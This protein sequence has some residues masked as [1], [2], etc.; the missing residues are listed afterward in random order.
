M[1]NSS[2]VLILRGGSVAWNQWRADNPE[3]KP[4]LSYLNFESTEA[5]GSPPLYDIVDISNFNFSNTDLRGASIRNAYAV[6]ASFIG[7]Y[8]VA[9]DLC[10]ANF[11]YCD[12]S[13]A[14]L[15]LSKIG[16]TEFEHCTFR[17]TDFAYCTAQ[18]TK[19]V[20]SEFFEVDMQYMQLA[21]TDFSNAKLH[22]AFVYGIAAWDL[23]LEGCSQSDLVITNPD[24]APVTVSD[25]EVAQFIYLMLNN[26]R[27]RSILNVVTS[28]VVLILGRF[29]EAR[30]EVLK[31]LQNEL[32]QRDYVPVI[33]DFERPHSR[34][35]LETA[36]TLAHMACFIVADFTAQ[37]DVRREVQHIA[38]T[39]LSVPIVPLLQESEK[40]L[41]ITLQDL[42]RHPGILP[43]IRYSNSKQLCSQI[44]EDIINPALA[45]GIELK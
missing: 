15:R 36:S 38:N 17:S 29:T 37:G 9:A 45:K 25:L 22:G 8:I 16:S 30:K 7:A 32:S 18:E 24:S 31:D 27:L 34:T 40:D 39:L 14:N 10:F 44:L 19:F 13:K 35:F 2:H 43:I 6:N 12:F 23:K 4:D 5:L 21:A 26:Q 42:K 1:S 3:I 41:P 20:N 11:C 33:F 28:K